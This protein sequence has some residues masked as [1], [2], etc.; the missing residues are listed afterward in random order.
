MF[1]EYPPLED[2]ATQPGEC[3]RVKVPLHWAFLPHPPRYRA[4]PELDALR[5]FRVEALDV[6]DA[7]VSK[8]KRFSPADQDDVAAMVEHGLVDH[9]AMVAQFRSAAHGFAGDARAEDLPRYV[10]NLHR[11][12]R[13]LFGVGPSEIEL[14][15]WI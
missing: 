11:V 7:V 3:A 5:S 9:G 12:E 10:R 13:D 8:L 6:V 1:E 4:L 2:T 15:D 14:P